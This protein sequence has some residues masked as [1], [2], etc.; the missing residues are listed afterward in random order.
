MFILYYQNENAEVKEVVNLFETHSLAYKKELNDDY[1]Q[2][3]LKDGEVSILGSAAIITHLETLSQ[4]LN[5]WYFC[6]C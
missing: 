3:T 4:E 1:A 6:D 5:Q 2:I